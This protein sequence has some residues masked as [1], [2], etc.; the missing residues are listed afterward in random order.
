MKRIVVLLL[1]GLTVGTVSAAQFVYLDDIITWTKNGYDYPDPMGPTSW[2]SPVNY[3]DGSVHVRYEPI[4]KP[5]TKNVQVQLCIWQDGYEKENCGSCQTSTTEKVYYYNYGAITSWWKKGGVPI[6]YTRIGLSSSLAYFMHKDGSCGAPILMTSSCGQACYTKTD[7]D[8]HVPI[9]FKVLAVVVSRGSSLQP[10][11][12]WNSP[13]TVAAPVFDPP[14]GNYP[15]GIRVSLTCATQGA[16]IFYELYGTDP[17]LHSR[18]YTTNTINVPIDREIKAVAYWRN[19]F[20][21]IVIG[22][23]IIGGTGINDKLPLRHSVSYSPDGYLV[24]IAVDTED[25]APD[26]TAHVFNSQ[27]YL[28]TELRETSRS[29]TEALLHWNGKDT[30]GNQAAPGVYLVKINSGRAQA[31][32]KAVIY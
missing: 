17:Y 16:R 8:Q 1:V 4:E 24:R 23:Y 10:I 14:P 20:S 6:D 12:G 27:G 22:K 15:E 5:S 9:T 7:I 32:A 13:A 25:I 18:E 3:R 19:S 28:I 11:E 31:L 26:L 21:S 30:Q 29:D 2:V